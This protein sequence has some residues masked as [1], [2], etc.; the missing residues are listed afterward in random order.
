MAERAT[1]SVREAVGRALDDVEAGRLVLVACSGGPDS[2]AL[3]AAASFVG[4]RRGWRAGAVIVDHQLQ[5]ASAGVAAHAASVCARLGLDPVT[6]RAVD[7]G[8]AGGPEAAAREARYAALLEACSAAGAVACLLGHTREDQAETVLLRLARGSGARSLSAMSAR[9]GLWRRPL[10]AVPRAVVHASA[11]DVLTP[12]GEDPWTDPHNLEPRFARVRVR[13]AMDELQQALGPGVVAGLARSATLLKDDADALDAMAD[14][15]FARH[16]RD[17]AIEAGVLAELPRAV[18]TR[19]LRRMC[20]DAGSPPGALTMEHVATVDHLV[21]QW[22]GQGR[23]SL[24]GG[25]TVGRI[26]GWVTV[27]PQHVLSTSLAIPPDQ[28]VPPDPGVGLAP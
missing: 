12:L 3:A 26:R 24:P 4:Q 10:L 13:A 23:T 8:T 20:V 5:A 16:V 27:V 25:V 18:R 11:R 15:E 2:L 21:T 6:I 14:V 19:V 28:G 7:V 9:T 22:H 17:G 1:L